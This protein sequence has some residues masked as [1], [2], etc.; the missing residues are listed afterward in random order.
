M[1]RRNR[2]CAYRITRSLSSYAGGM[3]D[4]VATKKRARLMLTALAKQYPDVQ[5][6]LDFTTPLELLAATVLSAE[7][8]QLRKSGNS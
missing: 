8:V 4:Q 2:G 7:P 5:C 1:S 3:E 6:E